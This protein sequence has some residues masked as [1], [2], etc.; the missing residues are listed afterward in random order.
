M[1]GTGH[2]RRVQLLEGRTLYTVREYWEWH[3][4]HGEP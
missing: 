1:E 4:S 3:R 2:A